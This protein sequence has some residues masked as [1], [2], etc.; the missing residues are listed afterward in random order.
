MVWSFSDAER[1]GRRDGV[2]VA[3]PV[4][5][6]GMLENG[7]FIKPVRLSVHLGTFFWRE[8]TMPARWAAVSVALESQ[9]TQKLR[10]LYEFEP[11]QWF[12]L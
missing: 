6:T 9:R 4:T 7:Q 5:L 1:E 11:C 8:E 10:V 2:V 3:Q 12:D